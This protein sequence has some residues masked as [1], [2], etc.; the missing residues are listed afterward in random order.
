MPDHV[1]EFPHS[2]RAY[3]PAARA[4]VAENGHMI[5]LSFAQ[6]G[7]KIRLTF[8]HLMMFSSPTAKGLARV[9]Y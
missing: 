9:D 5:N 3:L 4:L 1:F 7:L 2:L 6:R 8:K